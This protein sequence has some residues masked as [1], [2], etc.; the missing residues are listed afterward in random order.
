ML[1]SVFRFFASKIMEEKHKIFI[2]QQVY[3]IKYP[4]F[5]FFNAQRS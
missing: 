5:V 3:K 2:S 1:S 4:I